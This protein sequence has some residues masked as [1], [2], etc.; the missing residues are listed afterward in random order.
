MNAIA[1]FDQHGLSSST[2]TNFALDSSYTTNEEYFEK[3]VTMLE[4]FFKNGGMQFQ[5][6]HVSSEQ[7]L[8]AKAAPQKY[9]HLKVRVTGY[10][11]YFTRLEDVIQDSVIRRY[12]NEAK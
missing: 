3:T 6:N 8:E 4:T 9:N 7:L 10:S 1:K 5:L 11:D 12:G 2:V